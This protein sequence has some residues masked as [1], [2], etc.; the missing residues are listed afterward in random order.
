MYSVISPT[1]NAIAQF[2]KEQNNG[3][4]TTGSNCVTERQSREF[5][6]TVVLLLLVKQLVAFHRK[7]RLL[8]KGRQVQPR[9]VVGEAPTRSK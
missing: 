9:G 7:V 2:K 3:V 5:T 6:T 4:V 8:G 1:L